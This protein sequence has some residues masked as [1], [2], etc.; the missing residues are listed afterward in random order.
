MTDFLERKTWLG[1]GLKTGG[2][3]VTVGFENTEGGIMNLG[4]PNVRNWFSLTSVRFGLGLG[5]GTGLTAICVFN[6]DNIRRLHNTQNTD[7]GVNFALGERWDTVARTLKNMRFFSTVV[8]IGPSLSGFRPS[9]IETIRNGL[10]YLYNEYDVL[11]SGGDPKVVC[12]DTPA[13]AGLE[14]SLNFTIGNIEIS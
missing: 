10:H 5:G 6:C 9:H 12:I 3:M 1:V 14:V 7:W 4:N 11:L 2:T 13:S 8:R